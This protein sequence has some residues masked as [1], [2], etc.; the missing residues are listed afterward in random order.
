MI[1]ELRARGLLRP[2]PIQ[3][4]FLSHPGAGPRMAAARGGLSPL[5]LV[6]A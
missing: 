3:P 2:L 1:E 4:A 5:D 6:A